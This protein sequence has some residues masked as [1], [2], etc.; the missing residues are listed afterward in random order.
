MRLTP[1]SPAPDFSADSLDG[2]KHTLA[3]YA[4]QLL[5][6]GFFR[7]ATC[8]LCNLRVHQ[9]VADWPRVAGRINYLSIFQSPPER[10]EGYVSK[11]NPPFPVVSDPEMH[12]FKLYRVE[13]SVL[14]AFSGTVVSK[15]GQA[16]KLGMPLFD[17]PKDGGSFRVP[18]DFLIDQSGVLRVCRYG[19]NIADSIPTED[20]EKF[21]ASAS[22]SAAAKSAIAD[23]RG[24]V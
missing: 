12:L 7:F 19:K 2:G 24:A 20:V 3:D 15:M 6:L 11:Q 23:S 18:A 17:G 14:A 10:F 22:R 4:G 9:L 13:T 21:L 1:G 5:W 8:P 16:R